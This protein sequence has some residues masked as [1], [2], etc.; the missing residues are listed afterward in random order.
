MK[1]ILMTV[2][3]FLVTMFQ[4]VIGQE[5][6]RIN[7][8]LDKYNNV[9]S[10]GLA[11]TVTKDSKVIHLKG[12]GTAN[13]E[14]GIPITSTTVFHIGSVSKQFTA[15]AI[16]LLESQG[17][18][19]QNDYIGKYLKDLPDFKN[20]IKIK[21]LLHHTSG[22]REIETLQQIAGI[23]TADQIESSYLYNLIKNQKDLNFEPGEELEYSN[24]G[25][26][27][28][29]KI[30]ESV[31]GESIRDWA[32]ENIFIPLEMKHTEFYDDCTEII[33]N[34]AYPYWNYENRLI[35][36]ILSYSYV[37]P[38]SVM[39]T[40]E[41]MVKWLRNF[42]DIKVGND[43][44]INRMLTETDTLNSGE[45][46]DYGYGLGVT[47]YKGLNV[48]LHS[49]HDAAYRA[50]DLYFPEH[51]VGIALL[52]NYYS[53]NPLLSGY[54]I[55]NI[56]LKDFIRE[57]AVTD[58][59]DESTAD[60]EH[61]KGYPLSPGELIEYQGDYICNE[62][63][64]Q[65]NLSFRNDTLIAK[66]WRNEEVVL[67]PLK[68]DNFEGNASWFSNLKFFRD[69]NKKIVGFNL[70]AGRVRN[71]VFKRVVTE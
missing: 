30:V 6:E 66:F 18:L 53:I 19:S 34:R 33:R 32:S 61:T 22:L 17:K 47:D 9:N 1:N 3:L 52:S 28:L 20:K 31:T 13:L 46:I 41:D 16:L 38:T 49:G 5:I 43:E 7:K 71:L 68:S 14:Y 37:G 55:A 42:S 2:S 40:A 15:F 25:Y 26:F 21:H 56:I 60:Q 63:G 4:I 57:E 10:P 45:P 64:I 36:G 70:S 11:V 24:T 51:K 12:Y 23:T 54:E 44:I 50:A 58:N 8:M 39:T 59:I 62:L 67:S 29:A 48:V 27:L 65:Y 69:E 35:K